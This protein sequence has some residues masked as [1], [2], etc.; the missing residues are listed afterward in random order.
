MEEDRKNRRLQT[1]PSKTLEQAALAQARRCVI[2]SDGEDNQAYEITLSC[3]DIEI[4]HD[5]DLLD[6]SQV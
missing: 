6:K 4:L 3:P 2:E 5:F 1:P